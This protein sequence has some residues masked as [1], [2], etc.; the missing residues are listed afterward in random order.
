[1]EDMTVTTL[2]HIPN[3]TETIRGAMQDSV[4]M[5]DGVRKTATTETAI[6]NHHRTHGMLLITEVSTIIGTAIPI[7]VIGKGGVT[8][9]IREMAAPTDSGIQN[10]A[11]DVAICVDAVIILRQALIRRDCESL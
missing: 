3:D 2:R 7:Q 5:T 10:P 6:I 1:M 9:G 4:A 8:R 11:P